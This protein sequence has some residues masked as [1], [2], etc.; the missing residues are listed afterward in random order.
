VT[1]YQDVYLPMLERLQPGGLSN[2]KDLL[3]FQL[4]WYYKAGLSHEM[5]I[6]VDWPVLLKTLTLQ[7][8]QHDWQ[9]DPVQKRQFFSYIVSQFTETKS[10]SW[11]DFTNTVPEQRL[12]IAAALEEWLTPVLFSSIQLLD[13]HIYAPRE[14]P[15]L[16]FSNINS[17]TT[18]T[19]TL[20]QTGQRLG[21]ST[22]EFACLK[23]SPAL[24]NASELFA[25]EYAS[26]CD[27]NDFF[28][29]PN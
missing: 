3:D 19:L 18:H 6:E 14:N 8:E 25:D 16:M 11:L 4:H 17:P 5:T 10:I 13:A 12:A 7:L 24:P 29:F 15:E 22:I 21:S 20:G 23:T 26:D 1:L 27:V 28:K 9:F 2:F